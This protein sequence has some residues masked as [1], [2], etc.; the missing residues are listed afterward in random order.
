MYLSLQDL[1]DDVGYE[2]MHEVKS[3]VV[4]WIKVK[5]RLPNV[6]SLTLSAS[7]VDIPTGLVGCRVGVSIVQFVLLCPSFYPSAFSI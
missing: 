2:M 6:T 5:K 1:E 3:C 4:I 7:V